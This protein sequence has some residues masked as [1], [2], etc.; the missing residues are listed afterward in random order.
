MLRAFKFNFI[1]YSKAKLKETY[2]SDKKQ[3]E[4]QYFHETDE[5]KTMQPEL[6]QSI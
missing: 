3:Y 5:D 4:K 6:W 1:T 2:K